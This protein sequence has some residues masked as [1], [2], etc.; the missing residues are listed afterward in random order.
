MIINNKG[1][2]L[3]YMFYNCNSLKNF[4]IISKVQNNI[5]SENKIKRGKKDGKIEIIY[6]YDSI[7]TNNQLSYNFYHFNKTKKELNETFRN[8]NKS[9]NYRKK[10]NLIYIHF[11]NKNIISDNDKK[12]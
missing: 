4:Y 10:L 2:D 6:T 3:S 1:I 7:D 9:F 11:N 5:H 12:K 8:E